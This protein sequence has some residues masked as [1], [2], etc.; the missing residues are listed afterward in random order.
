MSFFFFNQGFIPSDSYSRQLDKRVAADEFPYGY[1][2][3][4]PPQAHHN[5]GFLDEHYIDPSMTREK[6]HLWKK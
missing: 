1:D 5:T 3:G 6:K 2:G 4:E